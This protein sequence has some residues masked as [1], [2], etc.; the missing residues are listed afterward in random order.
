MVPRQQVGKEGSLA[1]AKSWTKTS[2]RNF[3]EPTFLTA[4]VSSTVKTPAD[5]S[6]EG[7]HLICKTEG[8]EALV[9]RSFLAVTALEHTRG[10]QFTDTEI[11]THLCVFS[12]N[13]RPS[14]VEVGK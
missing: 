5:E 10:P 14:D 3:S 9:P 8:W 11:T 13:G 6:P 12:E 1:E 2:S 7:L 4:H